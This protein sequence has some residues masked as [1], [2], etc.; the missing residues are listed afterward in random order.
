MESPLQPVEIGDVAREDDGGSVT[1]Y[2]VR[3]RREALQPLARAG[4][5]ALL[6][7]CSPEVWPPA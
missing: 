2:D 7:A 3:A 1:G 4:L 5:H 6:A